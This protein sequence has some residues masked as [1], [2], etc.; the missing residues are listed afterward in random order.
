MNQ[1]K[2]M[3]KKLRKIYI[4]PTFLF[5]NSLIMQFIPITN[6]KINGTALL[7]FDINCKPIK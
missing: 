3:L 2:P 7:T 1:Q 5:K 4:N 6:A